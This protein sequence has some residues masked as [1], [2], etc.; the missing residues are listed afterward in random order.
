[1]KTLE[2][3]PDD[4]RDLAIVGGKA[5]SLAWLADGGFEVP[6]WTV[7]PAAWLQEF[8]RGNGLVH[9][10]FGD[11]HG[12]STIREQILSAPWPSGMEAKLEQLTAPVL[13][14]GEVATRSSGTLEDLAD[15]SF[16]G[17]YES[18]LELKDFG[19]VQ[20]GVRKCW[21]SMFTERVYE[22]CHQNDRTVPEL[23]M[24]VIVQQMVDARC[25]GVA[26]SV[27][28][29]AG[30]D[31]EILIE[32]CPGLGDELVSGQIDPDRYRYSWKRGVETD[33]LEADPAAPILSSEQVA[34][35]AQ[36]V[37]EVQ[38]AFGRPVDV[39]WAEQDGKIWLVQSRAVTSVGTSGFQGEWTTADFK[40]GGV[41]ASVCTPFMAA[42]Y[43]R[44]FSTSMPE[45]L[46]QV[47]LVSLQPEDQDW[48]MV[49]FGRPYWNAG[50]VK[51]RLTSLPGFKERSF[52]EDLGIRVGYEGDG[53]T[54][55]LSPKS[56][57][58]GLRVLSRLAKSFAHRLEV[59]PKLAVA[60]DQSLSNWESIDRA[61]LS[62]EEFRQ[63]LQRLL[64]QEYVQCETDYFRTIYDNSNAQTL[65]QEKLDAL[66]KKSADGRLDS[67]ALMGGLHDLS[68]LRPTREEAQML[69]KMR[70]DGSAQAFAQQSVEDLTAAY[71]SGNDFPGSKLIHA[72]LQRWG[73]MAPATLEIRM[74][75]WSENPRP[76]FESMRRALVSEGS[77]AQCAGA[78]VADAETRQRSAFD[79]AVQQCKQLMNTWVPGLSSRRH[80]SFDARL[81]TVRELLWWREEMRMHSTRMYATVRLWALE[82][83][84]RQLEAGAFDDQED[85]F[86]LDLD[87]VLAMARKELSNEQA[88]EIIGKNRCY[89]LG[90]RDFHN[91]DEI[92][93]RWLASGGETPLI[94]DSGALSG[95]G[96]SGG[97]FEGTARVLASV[98][99]VGRLEAGDVLVTRFTDP[100]W[101]SSFAGLGAVV[102]ETGGVLS[103]AAVIAREYGFPAVLAVSG[104]TQTIQ[105]GE[106]ILVDGD[107][108][109]V[110]RLS[111][112]ELA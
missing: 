70:A 35:L 109:R 99:E 57:V 64:E 83:G 78:T 55:S 46:D 16:A 112:E 72:Y 82:F 37:A 67:L 53:V 80:K 60:W 89:Y 101:T 100:G 94:S 49:A 74:P 1:M 50:L 71:R 23:T 19:Q 28:P 26:F 36:T 21:A 103:H 11:H 93:S 59:N 54:T 91:P 62:D 31:D 48:Y 77:T 75:R 85:V 27:D 39:E 47:A 95:I 81:K 108:G 6:P 104:A 14:G 9:P 29:I 90:F 25:A 5:A 79:H 13:A 2:V 12:L 106:R 68:H 84:K 66:A 45:Y 69:Q 63:S 10:E 44:V 3:N 51:Q 61:A 33:R 7:V 87:Q 111:A 56:I 18:Y 110:V 24:A 107:N 8:L 38:A 32:A 86:F 30:T 15:A 17:Q 22:Y 20:M 34:D 40:D 4:F 105:D 98:E 42:L 76:L 58:F 52:D 73:W 96:G 65:F 92:G 88:C 41:S 102:T 43:D 97:S